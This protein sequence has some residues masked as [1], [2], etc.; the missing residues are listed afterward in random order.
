MATF[1][2]YFEGGPRLI[3]GSKLNDMFNELF[4]TDTGIVANAGG[5]QAN[6]TQLSAGMNKI[7]TVT[8]AADSIK[9]PPATAG[10]ICLVRNNSANATQVFGSSPDTINGVA[11]GTGVSQAGST[12]ALY[13]CPVLGEWYRILS[14]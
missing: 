7:A 3:D 6:A 1:P 5:G 2:A 10:S 8:T 11:T 12:S 13:F 14:A 4:S 9:L